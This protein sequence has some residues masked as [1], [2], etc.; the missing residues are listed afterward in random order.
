MSKSVLNNKRILAVDD[1][2]DVLDTIEDLLMDYEGLI[3]DKAKDYETGY[4]LMHSWTYDLV[5]LDIMGVMGFDLLQAAVLLGIPAIMLSAHAV[6]PESLK[7]SIQMGA[8]AFIPKERMADIAYFMEDVLLLEHRSGLRNMF[9]RLA[10][11]FSFR[12]GPDWQKN[13]KA[14]WD[15]VASGNYEPVILKK[16]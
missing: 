14:F 11:Y 15:E 13:E 7:K 10:G 3:L 1:E 16:K 8:R 4:Q 5:T 9:D 6:S 2:P 12:F